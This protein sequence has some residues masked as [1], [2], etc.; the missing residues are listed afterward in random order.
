[1]R[2][3]LAIEPAHAGAA[4]L[5]GVMALEV[6][7]AAEALALFDRALGAS[8]GFA[9]LHYNRGNALAALQSLD[10]A[11]AAYRQCIALDPALAEAHFNL[12]NV[13]AAANFPEPSIAAYQQA[14]R[15]RPSLYEAW[16]R[17]GKLQAEAGRWREAA[18]SFGLVLEADAGDADAWNRRGIC[19]HQHGDRLA[20]L[21]CYERATALAPGLPEHWN[22]RGN[23]LHDLR[24]VD[25]AFASYRRAL[26]LDPGSPEATANLGMLEQE[27]GR[28]DQAR[29]SYLRA[30][31][32]RPRYAE[33]ARRLAGLD[34]LQRHFAAG[35][36]GFERSLDWSDAHGAAGNAPRWRGEPLAGRRILLSEPNGIGDTLQ[37]FRFVPRLVAAGAAVSFHGPRFIRA[38]VRGFAGQVDFVDSPDG[39]Y[40]FR[41]MLWSLPHYLGIGE[42]DLG[43]TTPYLAYDP[44]R[45]AR[46][47]ALVEPGAIN[48]GIC[49][50]GNPSRKIDALRSIPL[51]S[52]APLSRVPGL[53]LVCLQ[54]GHGR[55]QLEDLP[56]GMQVQVPGE[57][58]DAGPDAFADSAA[59]MQSLDLVLSADTAITHV[60]AGLGRP[61]WLALARVPDWRWMLDRDDSPWYPSVRLFRQQ[62]LDD[63]N[64]VFERIAAVLAAPGGIGAR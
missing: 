45:V 32:L 31:R 27:T 58:F 15:L 41:A 61:A 59:L 4:H 28:F 51:A 42:A 21:E 36:E 24:R 8:P 46:W 14:L 54:H 39:V 19:L 18:D 25:D 26:A 7:D 34:L 6:G 22:N 37:F 47:S 35:W 16:R 30:Q 43:M 49:W 56:E 50:Q 11:A 48:V 57:D 23:A 38:L 10:A 1:L 17:I 3:V 55:E 29:A 33:A 13:L 44:A 40:D 20:A 62:R 53:R 64:E 2:D 5:L 9:P 60:A 63:W 52:F 12:G